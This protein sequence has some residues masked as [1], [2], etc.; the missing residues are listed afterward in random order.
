MNRI[1]SF[2]DYQSEYK[3]SIEN[4]ET[5]WAEK[6]G[7]FVWRKPWDKVLEWDFTSPDI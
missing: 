5:F 4:P 6:A 3:K 7:S 1:T 2:A